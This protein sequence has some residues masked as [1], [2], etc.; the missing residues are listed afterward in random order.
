[1]KDF[2]LRFFRPSLDDRQIGV[3]VDRFCHRVERPH[4]LLFGKPARRL[5]K[6]GVEGGGKNHATE[7]KGH[8]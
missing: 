5:G 4:D 8:R 7:G 3:L 2:S 6:Q 1:M